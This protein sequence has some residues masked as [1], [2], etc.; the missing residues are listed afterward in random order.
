MPEE[1][2]YKLNMAD[3]LG[4]QLRAMLVVLSCSNTAK[5]EIIPDGVIGIARAFLAAGARSV[6]ESIWSVNDES[7]PWS[8]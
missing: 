7:I 5:G 1:K 4:L 2:D 3:V 8:S 6:L